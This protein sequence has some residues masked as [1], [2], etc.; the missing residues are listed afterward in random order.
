MCYG[1]GDTRNVFAEIKKKE[2]NS[3]K[4]AEEKI[5]KHVLDELF[6]IKTSIK[7]RQSHAN[8]EKQTIFISV[9]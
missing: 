2:K 6:G 9:F 5:A 4:K 3:E 8:T 1:Y 7:S